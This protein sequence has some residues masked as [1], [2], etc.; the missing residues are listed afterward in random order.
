MYRAGTRKHVIVS[1]AVSYVLPCFCSE[2]RKE[3]IASSRRAIHKKQH[4]MAAMAPRS[5]TDAIG[6]LV[7]CLCFERNLTDVAPHRR[8]RCLVSQ[9]KDGVN[10]MDEITNKQPS[11]DGRRWDVVIV[12]W[13][14]KNQG[15]EKRGEEG[16]NREFNTHGGDESLRGQHLKE[17]AKCRRLPFPGTEIY[18]H[19]GGFPG[20]K[21]PQFSMFRE[22]ERPCNC[23]LPGTSDSNKRLARWKTMCTWS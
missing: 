16:A 13:R 19:P 18:G 3:V 23:C 21:T 17:G 1:K 6:I 5:T 4:G 8:M 20:N 11:D 12:D 10:A 2:S 15:E 7:R 14:W 22:C 9:P